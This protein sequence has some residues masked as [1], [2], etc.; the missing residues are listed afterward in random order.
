MRFPTHH[1]TSLQ[2]QAD[3]LVSELLG[4]FGDNELSPE[5]LDGAQRLLKPGGISIPSSYTSFLAPVTSTKML[6]AVRTYKVRV[7]AW[8]WVVGARQSWRAALWCLSGAH[9]SHVLCCAVLWQLATQD[10]EHAETP[11]VV[12]LYR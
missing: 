3:I 8:D 9:R 10:L 6:E 2:T 4:S 11:Y 7:G 12:K 5:C 1:S